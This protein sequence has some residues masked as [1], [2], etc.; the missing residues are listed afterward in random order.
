MFLLDTDVLSASRRPD[1][2]HPRLAAWITTTSATELFLSVVSLLEIR[3][4]SLRIGR[5]DPAQGSV[6]DTWI[7]NQVLP[8]FGGRIIA[9]DEEIALRCAALHIPDPRPEH[10]AMIAATALVHGL[11]VATRNT[12]HFARMGV[13]LFN[14]W[15]DDAQ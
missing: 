12:V 13:P 11:T 6:L 10:D 14:P 15:A 9:F 5:R 1:K 8:Q 2:A 4:G 3:T 7:F